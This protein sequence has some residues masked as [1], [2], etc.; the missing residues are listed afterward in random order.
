MTIQRQYNLPN[1]IL[2]LEGMG[3]ESME[4][5]AR[6]LLSMLVNMEC[7][8]LGQEQV[9][10][11]GPDFFESF[12]IAVSQYAQEFLSG[13][14][15]RHPA[16]NAMVYLQPAEGQQHSLVVQYQA[17]SNGNRADVSEPLQLNLT[18]V[19]FF[20]LVEAIDQFFADTQTLPG[21]PLQ[22]TPVSKRE[23]ATQD[24]VAQRSVPAAVGV[25]TLALAAVAFF[26]VPVPEVQIPRPAS[27]TEIEQVDENDGLAESDGQE[28]PDPDTSNSDSPSSPESTSSE[29]ATANASVDEASENPLETE[30]EAPVL[31][32]SESEPGTQTNT[33]EP[34]ATVPD[35]SNP[36]PTNVEDIIAAAPEIKES[37][38]LRDLNNRLRARI[39]RAWTQDIEFDD[40]LTYRVAVASDGEIVGYR[41][42]EG[43]TAKFEETTPLPELLYLPTESSQVEPEPLAEYRVVFKPSGI[44]EVSPWKG[45]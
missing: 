32:E 4:L 1:C 2:T 43:P 30:P 33:D 26:M 12:A 23:G 28:G 19:Q 41:S 16:P 27:E 18:T 13:V 8:F 25:T 11:G 38:Q 45:F 29:P 44:L 35:Q 6:P 5:S 21:F 10:S 42:V 20:D 3:D 36:T 37:Q 15:R 7:R 31:E 9:L 14:Q 17:D 24:S 22:L 39:N 34:V 40:P